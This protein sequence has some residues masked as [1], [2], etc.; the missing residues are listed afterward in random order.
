MDRADPTETIADREIVIARTIDG[1]RS[2]VFEAFTDVAQLSEWW[3]PDGFTTTTRAFDFRPGGVWEFTM[4]GPDGV[5]YPNLIEWLEISPPERLVFRHGESADDPD[6]F[7]STVTISDHD[8]GSEVV[9]RSVFPTKARR[10]YVVE[11]FGAIEGGRQTLGRL[12]AYITAVL[13][14]WTG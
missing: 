6:A 9:L 14:D 1:P 10:D 4:H 7:V 11:E 3:G 12:A 8:H 13:D 5:D 2:R